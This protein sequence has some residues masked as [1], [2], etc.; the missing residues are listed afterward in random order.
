M[1]HLAR[2]SVMDLLQYPRERKKTNPK[3]VEDIYDGCAYQCIDQTRQ[4]GSMHISF[5]LNTDGVEIL[6]LQ[7]VASAPDDK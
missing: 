6:E 2:P 3:A 7:S 1:I 5:I 4:A